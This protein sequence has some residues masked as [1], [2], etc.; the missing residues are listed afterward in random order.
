MNIIKTIIKKLAFT[1]LCISPL[2]FGHGDDDPLLTKIMLDQFEL[3]QDEVRV[4][5]SELWLGKDL[6]KFWFKADWEGEAGQSESAEVQALYD[7][8]V[9]AN[10]NLQ[11][12]LRHDFA[13]ELDRGKNWAT[14]GIRGLAPY[15]I[16][17]DAALFIGDGGDTA[18]RLELEYELLLSQRWVLV[19]ELELNFYG[20]NDRLRQTGSGLSDSEIGLRLAYH[21]SRELAPYLGYNWERLHGNSANFASDANQDVKQTS[22]VAGI[23]WW[24]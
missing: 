9:T 21:F 23:R 15:F 18:L 19:P 1:S 20:Q 6:Q 12:G 10:W 5:E 3:R 2:V 17:V 24:F 11:L 22:W 4:L 13:L 7:M 14:V 16:D 8:A